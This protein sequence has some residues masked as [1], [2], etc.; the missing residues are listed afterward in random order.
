MSRPIHK[1]TDV[2]SHDERLFLHLV[3][4]HAELRHNLAQ[5]SLVGDQDELKRKALDVT[6]CWFDLARE[7][8]RDANTAQ[9]ARRPRATYS[10]A[11]YAVYNASK[12]VRYCV[13][14]KVSMRADDHQKAVD[15]PSDFPNLEHW[16]VRIAQ[17]YEHRL[18]ADYDNWQ[19]TPREQRMRP[20][21]CVE[22]AGRFVMAW[23]DYLQGKFG[24]TL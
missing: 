5:L 1:G 9:K 22:E 11:Y 13:F 12:A 16:T 21:K 7:H 15:L 20:R 14:G 6:R 2:S 18:R 23:R 4:N 3:K 19:L 10:R 8:L 24:A 17:L